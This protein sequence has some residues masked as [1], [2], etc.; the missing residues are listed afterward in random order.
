MV[1]FFKH[2]AK[3]D[4]A[5]EIIKDLL[6]SNTEVGRQLNEILVNGEALNDEIVFTLI[7]EKLDSPECA[8]YGY[9]LED[10]PTFGKTS[11]SPEQQAQHILSLK[12]S[13]DYVIKIQVRL[14]I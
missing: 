14:T 5:T 12:I 13:P 3:F 7:N 1:R 9:V 2:L 4:K 8:H 11:M 6:N 10:F